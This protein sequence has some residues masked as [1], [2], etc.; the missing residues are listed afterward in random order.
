MTDAGMKKLAEKLRAPSARDFARFVPTD[1][2]SVTSI[3]RDR[4]IFDSASAL[5]LTNSV[6]HE[7]QPQ[8]M[9]ASMERS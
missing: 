3:P 9:V 2:Y 7:G 4:D 1:V 6:C 5:S 8:R